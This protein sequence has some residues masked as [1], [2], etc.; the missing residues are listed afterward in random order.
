[1]LR[2]AKLDK[3]RKMHDQSKNE[4]NGKRNRNRCDSNN[5]QGL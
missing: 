3:K 4:N 2:S 1:M 5:S